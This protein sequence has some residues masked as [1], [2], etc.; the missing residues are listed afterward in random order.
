M[1]DFAG[2]WASN[3]QYQQ[4][5]QQL[6][7]KI[8]QVQQRYGLPDSAI[9][10][11]LANAGIESRWN[12]NSRAG[13]A[14]DVGLLQITPILAKEYNAPHTNDVN[15]QLDV[16]GQYYDRGL[17]RG[18][19]LDTLATGWNTG[20]GRAAQVD[21]GKR[22]WE[23]ITPMAAR[24]NRA[25]NNFVNSN[26]T[27]QLLN[28]L[29]IN[30]TSTQRSPAVSKTMQQFGINDAG[31]RDPMASANFADLS[32]GLTGLSQEMKP[33][34]QQRAPVDIAAQNIPMTDLQLDGILHTD[35]GLGER[36]F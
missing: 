12:V 4:R 36:L 5:I 33:V 7:P 34:T 28:N 30:Y 35:L 8:R 17:K 25:V 31:P 16:I 6:L 26:S 11:I 15:T 1:A 27:K 21:Q 24:Y 10:Y 18:L 23:S 2:D 9:P 22:T 29:G 32:E 20:M 3:P 13:S 19:N 14:N